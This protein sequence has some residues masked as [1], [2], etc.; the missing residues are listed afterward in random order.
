MS[1]NAAAGAIG[2]DVTYYGNGVNAR[3]AWNRAGTTLT[4]RCDSRY[5]GQNQNCVSGSHAYSVGV[6]AKNADGASAWRNS[7]PAEPPLPAPVSNISVTH[8]G[9]NLSVSWDPAARATHYDVTYYGNGVNARAAWNRAGTSL[10]ITCDS[11][12]DYQ[13]Q[14]CVSSEHSYN[15]GI[16][17]RNAYGESAWRNSPNISPPSD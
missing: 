1:W 14:N 6:R 10:T 2:Y 16:R 7:A 13:N 5:P 11:R 15:V 9:N 3:A 4:I 12:P 8:N 17:A